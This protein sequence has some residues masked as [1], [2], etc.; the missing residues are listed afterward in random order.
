MASRGLVS[1]RAILV[2]VP[3][4]HPRRRGRQFM[5]CLSVGDGFVE[6][7]EMVHQLSARVSAFLYR[8]AAVNPVRCIVNGV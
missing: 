8:R 6:I 3:C 2:A 4:S 5:V 7:K 1:S